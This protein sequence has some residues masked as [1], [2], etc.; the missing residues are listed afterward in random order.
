LSHK[1]SDAVAIPLW[2]VEMG[3]FSGRFRLFLTLP[4]QNREQHNDQP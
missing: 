3:Q 1:G 2:A 4:Q